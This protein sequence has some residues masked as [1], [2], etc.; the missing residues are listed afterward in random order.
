[1]LT[2]VVKIKY[3]LTIKPCEQF[4]LL[5]LPFQKKKVQNEDC[6]QDSTSQE[7]GL[8]KPKMYIYG[9]PVHVGFRPGFGAQC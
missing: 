8:M 5:L 9:D 7:D 6:N 4:S 1:M 3:L 2:H